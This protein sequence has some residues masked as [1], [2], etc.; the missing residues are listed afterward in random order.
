MPVGFKNGTDGNLASAINAMVA[1]REPQTF[2]GID[3][4]GH[5]AIVKTTGNPACHIVLRGGLRPNYDPISIEDACSRIIEY[6]LPEAI[7]VD[8]SHANSRKDYRGQEIVWRNIIAQRASGNPAL[9]GLMLESNL[10]AGSQDFTGD[11]GRLKYG[12]SITD[13]CISWE[14]TDKLLR[15]ADAQLKKG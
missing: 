11:R 14:T 7:M 5:T 10:I 3:Q 12:V 8:C 6:G 2:L 1:A 4:S 9:V 13:G 15:W